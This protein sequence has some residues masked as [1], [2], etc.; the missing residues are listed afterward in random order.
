MP[1]NE[2][3]AFIQKE[4]ERGN[5]EI[6]NYEIELHQRTAYPV[7]TYILTI[8]AVCV[9]CRKTRGGL[10]VH[11]MI[12]LLVALTYIFLMKMTSVAAT[13]AGLPPFLAVWTPNILFAGVAVIFYRWAR[14]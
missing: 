11:L 10:G 13:N 6:I 7:A 12:G 5:D 9:S 3:Y 2:L 1:S 14:R 4:K 8:I